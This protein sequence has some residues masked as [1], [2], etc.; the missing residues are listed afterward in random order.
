M[1]MRKAH[2]LLSLAQKHDNR[3]IEKAAEHAFQQNLRVTP[4]LF[5]RLLE[6]IEHEKQQENQPPL[7]K[8]SL[9]FVRQTDYFI[10]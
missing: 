2:G 7:S 4:K 8:Q 6:E 3:L 9:D 10:H 1:N 5:K